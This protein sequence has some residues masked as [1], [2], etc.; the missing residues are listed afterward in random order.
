MHNSPPPHPA[1]AFRLTLRGAIL[2]AV[3]LGIG[4]AAALR[5]SNLLVAVFG[6]LAGFA[7]VSGL[8]TAWTARR[9]EADRLPP[10]AV[11][12]GDRAAIGLRLRNTGRIWPAIGVRIEDRLAREGA[13]A[14]DASEPAVFPHV[15]P[16]RTARGTAGLM[17]RRRG[18]SVLGPAV[19]TVSF[20]PGLFVCRRPLAGRMPLLV[21][22]RQATLR[23]RLLGRRLARVEYAETAAAAGTAGDHEFAG[24]RDY[25]PGDPLRRV[26]WKRSARV[27]GALLVREFEDA[28]AREAVILLDTHLPAPGRNARGAGMLLSRRPARLERVIV[29]A[30]AL[31]DLLLADGYTVRFRAFTPDD[32]SVTVEPRPGAIGDLLEALARLEPSRNRPLADLLALENG[33]RGE[34]FFVLRL[35]DAPL[36]PWGPSRRAL[37]LDEA[38][39]RAMLTSN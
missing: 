28:A 30:A 35:D 36:P 14:A 27:P 25:R 19:A 34:I 8:L 7:A 10:G 18:R 17:P 21:Y 20:P 31:A 13:G 5:E 4:A 1:A 39:M 6:V 16:A 9:L 2:L 29:F 3:T 32:E 24:L 33:A 22:P 38:E 11:F 37:V 12:A 23:R 15:A 26:H